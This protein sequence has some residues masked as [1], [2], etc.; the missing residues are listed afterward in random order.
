MDTRES[1]RLICVI[2]LM[3][4]RTVVDRV[5]VLVR[6]AITEAMALGVLTHV[7]LNVFLMKFSFY[8]ILTEMGMREGCPI[9]C[10]G[11]YLVED[12]FFRKK[13]F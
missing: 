4:V 8:W 9:K 10:I 7:C 12:L 1:D 6:Q 13:D 3:E 11:N 5:G 2:G